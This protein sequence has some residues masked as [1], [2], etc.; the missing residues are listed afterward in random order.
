MRV[1]L[2]YSVLKLLV[3]DIDLI[4]IF[5]QLMTLCGINAVFLNTRTI[6]SKSL[7]FQQLNGPKVMVKIFLPAGAFTLVVL[8]QVDGKKEDT[9]P[10]FKL[11]W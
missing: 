1:V 10:L 4:C 7:N 11:L 6:Y 2:T 9:F 5:A 8:N 3:N